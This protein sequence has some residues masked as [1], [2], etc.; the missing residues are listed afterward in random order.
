MGETKSSRRPGRFPDPAAEQ[1][2]MDTTKR[3]L[4]EQGYARMS[5]DAVARAA[6]VARTTIYR[7]YPN[8]AQLVA[9]A[10]E[11]MRARVSAPDTGSVRDDL[12]EHLEGARRHWEISLAGAVFV[13][14]PHQPELVRLLRRRVVRPRVR[15]VRDALERGVRRG[16]LREDLDVDAV[17]E[18]LLGAYL[19]HQLV[20]GRPGPRWPE[21]IVDALWPGLIR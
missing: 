1:L 14:A 4:A 10:I 16:E 13:D 5:I 8:K 20:H 18:L 12:I 9:A 7:R 3:L 17:S 11:H 6:G 19:Q 21:R 15:F 2:I